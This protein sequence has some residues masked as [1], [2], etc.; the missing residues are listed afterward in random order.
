MPS[1]L[2]RA[3][4]SLLGLS[5]FTISMMPSAFRSST[6]G[7]AF[8]MSKVATPLSL[9]ILELPPKPTCARELPK[10]LRLERPPFPCPHPPGPSRPPRLGAAAG[11]SSQGMT[12]SL[13]LVV[14]PHRMARMVSAIPPTSEP[15]PTAIASVSV[16][17]A[18]AL[19]TESPALLMGGMALTIVPVAMVGA[20]VTVTPMKEE[21]DSICSTSVV[22]LAVGVVTMMFTWVDAALAVTLILLRAEESEAQT[23]GFIV[24]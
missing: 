12:V 16:L 7:A 11:T 1:A 15:T 6:G 20:D 19:G 13:Q 8:T 24:K 14:P 9:A 17:P 10:R 23:V 2:T 3:E 5:L 18:L 22:A 4:C 21:V